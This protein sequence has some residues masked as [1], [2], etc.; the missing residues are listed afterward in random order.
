MAKVV[1]LY[2]SFGFWTENSARFPNLLHRLGIEVNPGRSLTFNKTLEEMEAIANE[3]GFTPLPIVQVAY[4]DKMP[5]E[6]MGKIIMEGKC[7][8][9][10]IYS[11]DWVSHLFAYLLMTPKLKHNLQDLVVN[12]PP[13]GK[14]SE[15]T[16]QTSVFD[17]LTALSITEL[18][19]Q[20]N[21]EDFAK[22]VK[23][24]LEAYG[25]AKVHIENV[26][27]FV[28]NFKEAREKVY[29][30]ENFLAQKAA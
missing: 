5:Q 8:V 24:A 19:T 3:L 30:V 22:F 17:V 27:G 2:S 14:S 23:Y 10:L 13:D 6:E 15:L 25:G 29:E 9:D 1:N 26:G 7:A 11:H 28:H 12:L 20:K 16:K 4:G 18:S 21:D